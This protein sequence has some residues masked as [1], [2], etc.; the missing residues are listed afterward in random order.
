MLSIKLRINKNYEGGFFFQLLIVLLRKHDIHRTV[1]TS[2]SIEYVIHLNLIRYR[3][4][5]FSH[6][7]SF[8]MVDIPPNVRYEA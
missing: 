5:Y 2:P 8:H 6:S 1:S 4:Q 3:L 7:R